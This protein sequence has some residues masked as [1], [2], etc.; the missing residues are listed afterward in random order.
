[1][2][3]AGMAVLAAGLLLGATSSLAAQDGTDAPEVRVIPGT[4]TN[5]NNIDPMDLNFEFSGSGETLEAAITIP[6]VESLRIEMNDLLL[7]DEL[8]NFSFV[9]PSGTEVIECSLERLSDD[10]FRGE[11]FGSE[12]SGEMTIDPFEE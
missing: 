9:E 11:C 6:G 8:F 12:G 7:T 3:T 4:F 1:M 2:K 5:E 10:S